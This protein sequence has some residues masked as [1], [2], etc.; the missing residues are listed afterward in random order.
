MPASTAV[1]LE[2][3]A[4]DLSLI[5]QH[6]C[7]DK[8]PP[9]KNGEVLTAVPWLSQLG[10]DAAFAPGDCGPACVAMW[11]RYY[12]DDEPTVDD[13]SKTTG[14]PRGYNYTMPAHIMNSMR[15]YGFETYWRR[16][17]SLT[18]LRDELDAQHPT[19][20]L[21]EY[22][23]LPYGVRYDKAYDRGHWLLVLGYYE[24]DEIGDAIVYH[25]PYYYD[26][27]GAF[28]AISADAFDVAW[29]ANHQSGNSDR[30]AIRI[31]R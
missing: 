6:L 10:K 13:V 1:S 7:A 3:I 21:V 20:C 27:A 30:Q 2:R 8:P 28:I 12:G 5:R 14:L 26:S 22:D 16:N 24:D 25:D 29:S 23:R 19:I 9:P 15:H 11:V 4:D 17:L 31:R 18:A